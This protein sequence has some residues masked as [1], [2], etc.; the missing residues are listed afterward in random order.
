MNAVLKAFKDASVQLKRNGR[1]A[2]AAPLFIV[3]V[4]SGS[5]LGEDNIERFEDRYH[6]A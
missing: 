1:A 3:E 2:S 6:R 4:Q 5:Y